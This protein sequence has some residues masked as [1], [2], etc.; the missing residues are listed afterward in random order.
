MTP[1]HKARVALRHF[2]LSR[3]VRI[4]SG[5]AGGIRFPVP[6]HPRSGR[7][8]RRFKSCHSDQYLTCF[9]D[10][11]GT[12]CGT[13]CLPGDIG[14][15]RRSLNEATLWERA[16]HWAGRTVARVIPMLDLGYS[17]PGQ[18]SC[19]VEADN[20]ERRQR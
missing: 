1:S 7:G 9:P 3:G 17:F 16:A 6:G 20:A 4:E 8:G 18:E 12:D 15:H 11:T 2:F 13:D 5:V 19:W 14:E 10:V